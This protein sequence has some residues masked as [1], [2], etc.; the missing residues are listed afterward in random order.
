MGIWNYTITVIFRCFGSLFDKKFKNQ[1]NIVKLKNK[2][3]KLKKKKFKMQFLHWLIFMLIS[4]IQ[5]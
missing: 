5:Y 2:I 4:N 3:K 1:Y